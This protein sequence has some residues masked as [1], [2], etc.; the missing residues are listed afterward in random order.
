MEAEWKVT[1]AKMFNHA[2]RF[3]EAYH[4][5]LQPICRETGLSPMAVDIL[6][7]VANHPE[8]NTAGDICRFRGLKPGIVSVHV[9]RLVTEG[10]LARQA[11]PGD[12][13][14]TRLVVASKAEPLIAEGWELQKKFAERLLSGLEESQIEA[15]R[16]CLAAMDHNISEIRKHGV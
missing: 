6:M 8:E 7:F 15:F 1:A 11:E 4:T 10:L 9:D 2:N 5:V 12:R 3:V 16:S 14:K 13:R